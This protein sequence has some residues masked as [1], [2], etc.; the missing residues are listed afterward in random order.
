VKFERDPRD[1]RYRER[2]AASTLAS[3]LLHALLALLL[4][5]IISSSSQEGATENV[6]GGSIVT[7]E[8]RSPAVVANQAAATRAVLPIAH[9]PRIAPVA[10]APNSQVQAQR[11]PQNRHELAREAP[12]APPNPRP[13][14]QQSAQPNPQPTQNVYEVQ[15]RPE[16]PAAPIS[17][18]TVAPVAVALKVAASTAPSPVPSAVA[19]PVRSPKPPA[20][21]AAPVR[22][23]SPAPVTS[24]APSAAPAAVRATAVPSASPAPAV[25]ASLSPAPRSG[26]PSPSA[27]AVAASATTRGVAA[28]PGPKGVGSPGPRPGAGAKTQ[29]APERPIELRPTP[30]PAPRASKTP[31]AAPNINAKLRSLLPNNPV[32]PTSKQYSPSISLHGSL[33][34]TPPP[35]VLAQ[36]KYLYRSTGSTDALVEMWVTS[37]RKAGPTTIC[38]GW[39]VRY[40]LNATAPHAGDYAPANGTQI[41]VGGGRGTPGTLPPIVDGIVTQPCEGHLLVPFVPSPAT[42]P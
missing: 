15:P 24:V 36:T 18:P 1:R 13:L 37:I 26:V 31:P 27:T 35:A 7:L 22:K 9:V 41:S 19:T 38:T 34:P 17:V 29:S 30:S 3:I 2:L 40:P 14:P 16:A 21:T 23:P 12:T 32:N 25:R 6:E 8:R 28:S 5:S 20:P 10:H 33:R 42:S 4:V 11:L 39:L